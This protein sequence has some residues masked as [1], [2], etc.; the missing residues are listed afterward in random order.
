VALSFGV[1]SATLVA[2]SAE[3]SWYWRWSSALYTLSYP[4]GP[5]NGY[6]QFS[7]PFV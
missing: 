2:L 5:G 6:L 7:T 3:D 1:H 4:F